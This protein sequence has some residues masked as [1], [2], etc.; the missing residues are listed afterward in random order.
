MH[1]SQDALSHPPR[2][3]PQGTPACPHL[4]SV[5]GDGITVFLGDVQPGWA[6]QHEAVVQV[7]PTH[8][9]F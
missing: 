7:F 2:T 5:G 4:E 9:T 8:G 1:R 6:G 3:T